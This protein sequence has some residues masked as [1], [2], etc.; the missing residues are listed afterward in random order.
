M[1]GCGRACVRACVHAYIHVCVCV[2]VFQ[3]FIE[4]FAP[5][6]L[7]SEVTFTQYIPYKQ[8]HL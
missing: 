1:G 3:G 8:V 6:G 7:E 2:Q 4:R 5:G